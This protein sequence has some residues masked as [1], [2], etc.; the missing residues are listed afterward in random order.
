M[1]AA[2]WWRA[3]AALPLQVP[4]TEASKPF[5][6]V[7]VQRNLRHHCLACRCDIGDK[8]VDAVVWDSDAAAADHDD[9]FPRLVSELHLADIRRVTLPGLRSSS[10]RDLGDSSRVALAGCR[11]F[12][13]PRSPNC[14][15]ACRAT[16][17]HGWRQP[18]LCQRRRRIVGSRGATIP[19][20]MVFARLYLVKARGDREPVC[21]GPSRAVALV[22]LYNA[23]AI[24]CGARLSAGAGRARHGAHQPHGHAIGLLIAFRR[25]SA[26][27][28]IAGIV[29]S[30]G[31]MLGR[32]ILDGRSV[33]RA[34]RALVKTGPAVV[35][36]LVALADA[37]N[38]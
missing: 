29:V 10:A 19:G 9:W 25:T 32:A 35:L 3:L 17:R 7:M 33:D 5:Q 11:D 18:A 24:S 20:Q 12:A 16:R 8:R 36:M 15:A 28:L 23:A 37:D 31:Y 13:A 2:P 26:P 34:A 27:E 30:F 22:C 1:A 6:P 38:R 21:S 4:A 14:A